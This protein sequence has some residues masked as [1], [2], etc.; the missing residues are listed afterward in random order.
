MEEKIKDGWK[1]GPIKDAERKEHPCLV[2][3]DNLPLKQKIKDKIFMAIVDN[4]S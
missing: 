1:Y 4:L 2:P 3:Y